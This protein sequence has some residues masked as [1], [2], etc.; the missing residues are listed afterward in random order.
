M[1]IRQLT[2]EASDAA[3]DVLCDAFHDY[4]VMRFVLGLAHADYDRHL[5]TLIEYFVA[6]RTWRRE[7]VLGVLEQDAVVAAALVTLPRDQPTPPALAAHRERVWA[8]LG[9]AARARYEAFGAACRPFALDR[10]HHHLNMIGVRRAHAGR[11]LGR[12]LLTAVHEL[13]A[14]DP[15]S[16]GVTLTTEDRRN[17]ALYERAG[18]TRVGHVRVSDELESWGFYRAT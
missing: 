2:G 16:C 10:P 17:L 1:I 5:H 11:G 18:Y 4:P 8:D 14:R 7:P 3:V 9:A 6:A 12:L 13:A 15:A